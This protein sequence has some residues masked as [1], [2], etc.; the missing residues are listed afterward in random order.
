MYD[1]MWFDL[2]EGRVTE[3][4]WKEFCAALLEQEINKTKDVMVRLKER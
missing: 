3:E 2:R 4:E 1:M